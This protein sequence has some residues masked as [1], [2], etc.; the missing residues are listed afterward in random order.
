MVKMLWKMARII[1]RPRH[2]TSPAVD[3]SP[4]AA[5]PRLSPRPDL[6]VGP[7][8]VPGLHATQLVGLVD[9]ALTLAPARR[10]FL[11]NSTSLARNSQATTKR[12]HM[13]TPYI[14]VF[15]QAFPSGD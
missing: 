7:E 11:A 8:D 4:N 10:A 9:V 3:Q 14:E 1:Y 12:R 5:L 13:G 15:C 2:H 6:V